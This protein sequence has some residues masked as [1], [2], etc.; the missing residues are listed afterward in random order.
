MGTIIKKRKPRVKGR[1][2]MMPAVSSRLNKLRMVFMS[3]L[4]F[5]DILG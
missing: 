1:V 5:L 2:N 4:L 3:N